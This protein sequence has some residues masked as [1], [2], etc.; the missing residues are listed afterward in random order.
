MSLYTLPTDVAHRL[1]VALSCEFG[2]A[3]VAM[4]RDGPGYITLDA[5]HG[6]LIGFPS[7]HGVLA[8]IVVW[9]ARSL[10]P[11]FWPLLAINALILISTPIQGGHHLVDVLASFPVTALSIWLATRL[12]KNAKLPELVNEPSK[13]AESLP[14]AAG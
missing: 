9:Y 6:S 3:Q 1:E 13:A 5:L 8:L 4:L 14:A 2:K 12:A 10:P 7:Y 11:L